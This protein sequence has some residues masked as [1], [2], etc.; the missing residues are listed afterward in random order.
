MKNKLAAAND[1]YLYQFPHDISCSPESGNP[2]F[3]LTKINQETDNYRH[4]IFLLNPENSKLDR[5]T[6]SGNIK[7]FRWLSD[8]KLLFISTD[9]LSKN[10]TDIYT[11]SLGEKNAEKVFSIPVPA[12]LPVP[13]DQSDWL[14]RTKRPVNPKTALKDHAEEGVD[15]WSFTDTPFL[16]NGEDFTANRRNTLGIFN[17]ATGNITYITGK[18]YETSGYD[19]SADKKKYF[20]TAKTIRPA[21][22]YTIA[23]TFMTGK[24]AVRKNCLQQENIR[25]ASPNGFHPMRFFFRHPYWTARQ[26]RTT[27]FIC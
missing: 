19:I 22:P 1:L 23:F 4:D 3:I 5:L 17:E 26:R 25:S 2:A 13:L 6:Q 9:S 18:Y 21:P 20:T 14:I 16:R 11:L 27:I 8:K 12:E 15:F 7:A 24:T 10:G